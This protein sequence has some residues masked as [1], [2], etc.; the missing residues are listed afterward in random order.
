MRG[1][2]VVTSGDDMSEI[3]GSTV[4]YVDWSPVTTSFPT[5]KLTTSYISKMPFQD[6]QY[7][8]PKF[9]K[10]FVSATRENGC[11]Q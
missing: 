6:K 9:G 3:V 2:L 4:R 5:L 8:A 10:I 1:S 7:R 11:F